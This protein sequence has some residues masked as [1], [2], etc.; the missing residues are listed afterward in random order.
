M[1]NKINEFRE[2]IKPLIGAMIGAGCGLSSISFYTHSVFV[3]SISSDTG[4]SR[5]DVQ[6]GVSI[7]ILLAI[8]TA[9]LIGTMVDRYGARVIGL[10]SIPLYGFAMVCF[11][12]VED[13]LWS[14]Y[15]IWV[16]MSII[17]AGT[18]PVTWTR[19]VNGW[20]DRYRGIA[21]GVT[22]AGTGIAATLGPMYVTWLIDVYGWRLAY[23]LLAGTITII[24]F[25]SVYFLFKERTK[26]EKNQNSN[27]KIS[28]SNETGL[29]FS[30]AIKSY[31]FWAIGFALI[32]A[33][34]GI[35]GL[36][37]NSVPMLID[38]GLTRTDAAEYAGLIG[39]S[40]IIGRLVVGFLL[41]YFWA[42]LIAAIF[43]AAPIF[44]AYIL[45]SPIESSFY[46][47]LSMIII[48]LAAGA[49]LDLLAFLVSRYFGLLDYGKLYGALYIFFS[50]GA[51]FAPVTF[52]K[53][54]DAF[55]NYSLVLNIVAVM[56]VCSGM[57][58]LTLGSYPKLESK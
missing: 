8:I 48:G 26:K 18:L 10:I 24:S 20:F 53:T 22:L 41:D 47:S 31:R 21:L 33:A 32:L 29:I 45:G 46:I 4:W 13:Q 23:V 52:G 40:V 27:G 49:E 36:I 51:G 15:L 1:N 30:K 6:L 43:L 58:M 28:S 44:S 25:P 42:P 2:G 56:S 50:L 19:V 12:F 14:Y 3:S 39:L 11:V 16:L 55:G 9:P 35:S 17:A 34:A 57:L 37:T 54:F 5:G 38:K 7:M